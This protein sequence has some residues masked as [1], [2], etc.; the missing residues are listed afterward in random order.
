MRAGIG[1]YDRRG[2]KHRQINIGMY[3]SWYC[4]A[5]HTGNVVRRIV[6]PPE[7]EENSGGYN[8][9]AARGLPGHLHG[10][11]LIQIEQINA[12]GLTARDAIAASKKCNEEDR[13]I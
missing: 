3:G 9:A 2:H 10:W 4:G 6:G 11:V 13:V 12:I 8:W 1:D 7:T 5:V